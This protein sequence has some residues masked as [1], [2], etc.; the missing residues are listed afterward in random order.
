MEEDSLMIV[1]GKGSTSIIVEGTTTESS[2]TDKAHHAVT[3]LPKVNGQP[4]IPAQDSEEVFII[5]NK[6]TNITNRV[7]KKK[8]EKYTTRLPKLITKKKKEILTVT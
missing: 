7:I 4:V 2:D 6:T 3:S 8:T 5:V 1:G